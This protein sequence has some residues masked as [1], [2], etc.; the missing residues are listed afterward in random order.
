MFKEIVVQPIRKMQQTPIHN[1]YN[2][3]VL[4][5]M[6]PDFSLVVE[7]G[8]S[9]GALAQAYRSI[10]PEA[11]YT[12]IEIVEEYAEASRQHCTDVTYGD[13]EKLSDRAF[14]KLARADC[15]I[16]A[17]ALEHLY[18][19]WSVLQRIRKHAKGPVE[20]IACIPN[21]QNWGVQYSLNSGNF[22]YQDSGLLD[23][24]HIRWFT[25]TTIIDLFQS[26]GFNI[27]EMYS[28]I[29]Q[30]PNEVITMAIRQ[31]AIASGTDPDVAEQDAIPFQYVVRAVVPD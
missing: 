13:V 24:T 23:R 4:N 10:N 6:R 18:D 8:S 17:D 14:K 27:V 7:V 25:R 2:A 11:N 19:P 12:G 16:F 31:M 3:D 26:A 20:I 22:V 21:A 15:W 9:S 5:L 1:I 29:I 28:R 30:K